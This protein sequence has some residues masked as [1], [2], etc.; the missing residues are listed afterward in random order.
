M[1]THKSALL[2]SGVLLFCACNL[3]VGASD[4]EVRSSGPTT[5]DAAPDA[6]PPE[7]G[8]ARECETN[9]E[10]RDRN[11]GLDFICEK[12]AHKCQSLTNAD[13][14]EVLAGRTTDS[15]EKKREIL[16]DDNTLFLGFIMDLNGTNVGSGLARRNALSLQVGEFHAASGSGIPGGAGGRPRALAWVICTEVP[17][18]KSA[19]NARVP[20]AHLINEL[21]VP[22]I[23]GTQSTDSALD[24]FNNFA[25]PAGT[26]LFGPSLS[27]ASISFLPDQDLF[28]RTAPSGVLQA[29]ALNRQVLELEDKVKDAHA[30]PKVKLALVYSDEAFGNDLAAEVKKNL[31]FNGQAPELQPTFLLEAKYSITGTDADFAALATTINTF[32][33]HIVL[34]IGR[35]ESPKVVKALEAAT[36]APAIRPEWLFTASSNVAA[37]RNELTV[38]N[39]VN[40]VRSR[41]RGVLAVVPPA[42]AGFDALYASAGF[43]P[44]ADKTS[45]G[46]S[47]AYDIGY[48]L[49]YAALAG[50]PRGEPVTG[51]TLAQGLKTVLDGPE[52]NAIRVGVADI[53]RAFSLLQS[54]AHIKVKGVSYEYD[55]DTAVGEAPARFDTWCARKNGAAVELPTTG[56]VFNPS[57]TPATLTGTFACP[58]DN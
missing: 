43:P 57:V 24:L 28:W 21:H 46:T 4:Y 40:A 54:G 41:M 1:L 10:C 20:G 25:L 39:N 50:S 22:A 49:T 52:S 6:T 14:P 16:A 3:V 11:G 42:G 33:P 37:M 27:S 55:F 48:L 45:F 32:Q 30:V 7:A 34:L 29:Q 17:P 12:T 19:A 31:V 35:S 23:L 38:V 36:P 51:R 53:S 44:P 2:A 5:A 8:P 18:D 58:A 9:Q 56:F 13:C 15:P 26:L 47:G